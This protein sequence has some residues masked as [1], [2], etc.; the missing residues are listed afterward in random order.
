MSQL[1]LYSTN[2]YNVQ[3]NYRRDSLSAHK[4]RLHAVTS[5]YP[6]DGGVHARLVFRMQM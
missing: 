6:I 3:K 4:T 2:I 1:L 5:S